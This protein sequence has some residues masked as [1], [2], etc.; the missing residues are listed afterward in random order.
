M[1]IFHKGFSILKHRVS[2]VI[3][4]SVYFPRYAG[5]HWLKALV[6]PFAVIRITGKQSNSKHIFCSRECYYKYQHTLRG[7]N[8]A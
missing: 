1:V 2:V 8:Q 5:N 7:I 4:S 3:T 6:I